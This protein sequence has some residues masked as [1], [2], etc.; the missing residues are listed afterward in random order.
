MKRL[1]FDTE[2]NYFKRPG[3][4]IGRPEDHIEHFR[5]RNFRFDCAVVYDESS[6]SFHEFDNSQAAEL[7]TILASATELVSHSGRWVDLMVLEHACGE[8][9][10]KPL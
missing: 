10:I 9:H 8:E 5:G 1:C 3:T 2:S 6:D 4:A 7:V